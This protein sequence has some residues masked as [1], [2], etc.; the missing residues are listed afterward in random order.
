M[1]RC[2]EPST[3]KLLALQPLVLVQSTADRSCSLN[4][5]P[6]QVTKTSKFKTGQDSPTSLRNASIGREKRRMSLLRN[7]GTKKSATILHAVPEPTACEP[8]LLTD[9][10]DTTTQACQDVSKSQPSSGTQPSTSPT[11]KDI[12][13]SRLRNSSSTQSPIKSGPVDDLKSVLSNTSLKGAIGVYKHGKIHWRQKDRA[14]PERDSKNVRGAEKRLRP[15]I[16]VVIPSANRDRPLPSLPFFGQPSKSHIITAAIQSENVH[17]VSPPSAGTKVVMRNSVVSPLNQA[18]PVSS[19]QF[20]RS[21]SRVVRKSSAARH[22]RNA[23]RPSNSSN[24]SHDSDSASTYSNRSS[25]TSIEADSPPL[26]KKHVRHYSVQNPVIAGVFDSSPESYVKPFMPPSNRPPRR[27]TSHTPIENN[28]M[29]SPTCSL[30]RT[31]NGSGGLSRQGTIKRKGSKCSIRSRSLTS[32]M[33]VID[34]AISRSTSRQL[35]NP[36]RVASPTLS[37]AENDLEE[38]LTSFAEDSKPVT[39]EAA[40]KQRLTTLSEDSPFQWDE[41][42]SKEATKEN[43]GEP[44]E[45]SATVGEIDIPPPALPRKSSKRQSVNPDAYRLSRVPHD[46]IASQLERGRSCGCSQRLTIVIP[47]KK[48]MSDDFK[49]SPLPVPPKH[50]KRTITPNSAED[51]IL[52]IFLNLDNFNDLFATAVVNRGFYRVFKRHEL[53]LIKSTLRKMSP[54]AWEFREIAFPGH[55]MLHDEDLEM[56]RPQEEYTASTYLQSYKRDVKT[57][58]AI[59]SVV[60]EKC[61]SFVRPEISIALGSSKSVETSR[62]DDALWRIWTFCKIFGSGKG[63]EDDIVAQQDWLRGGAM[64]HQQACTS[65]FMSTDFMNDTLVG[66]PECFAKGNEGGLTAEQLFDMMEL[67]NCLGVLLQ[68]FEGH[69]AQA[70]E[71]GVY[72]NTDIRG[73]DI[74]GEEMMLA[75]DEWCYHLLTFGLHTVLELSTP[76]HTSPFKLAA[77][78]G[79]TNW[80]P[81]VFNG[82]RRAFLKEAA[83]RVYEDKIA[84]TYATTSTRDIQRQLSKMRIQN[85]ITELRHRKTSGPRLPM[86]RMSQERPMSEWSTVMTNLTRPPPVFT[87]EN[88]VVSHIPP[89]RS[90]ST[91]AQE[92][93][94]SIAELPTARTPPPPSTRSSSPRRPFAQPLLPTPPP[95]TVP[96]T[97]DRSSVATSMPSIEEHPQPHT[98]LHPIGGYYNPKSS[99]PP[100]PPPSLSAHPAF[101]HHKPS[102]FMHPTPPSQARYHQPATHHLHTHVHHDSNEHPAFAQHPTQ[103]NIFSSQAHENT[104]DKAIY[105]IVEMGFTAEQAREA[106]RMTDPGDGLRVDRAIELLLSRG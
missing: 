62:I 4:L 22:R 23:S 40:D 61:Q 104:A 74:D 19:G 103:H 50:I 32:T 66:A 41:V 48:R 94:A 87:A 55:D 78:H 17:D 58:G 46:H 59:E 88:N 18:Q 13:K 99:V 25:E 8:G 39:Q 35:S 57:V 9:Q 106:L 81:P 89:L 6:P 31:R 92:L 3:T 95:S 93:T 51:V 26:D 53:D 67:W 54:P 75:T 1:S 27:Y 37:E 20:Q 64:V 56:T 96:S 79:W 45:D 76:L 10:R 33:G 24:D 47:E 49:L 77:Q 65:S 69:T 21:L 90:S 80:T 63:R 44:R 101:R 84:H 82:S 15:K 83:S 29:F 68:G 86:I 38:E 102:S 5:L 14:S 7:K 43:V 16:Q 30:Q 11:C 98:H 34:G 71:Y 91:L 73:G 70:R 52:N 72:D 97:R 2:C 60:K 100:L 105:R 28:Y 42:V 36:L 12:S 85:H